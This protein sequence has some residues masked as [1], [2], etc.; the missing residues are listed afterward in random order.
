[1]VQAAT[2]NGSTLATIREFGADATYAYN[3]GKANTSLEYE[4][5][6]SGQFASGTNTVATI[7]VGFNNVAWAGTVPR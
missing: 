6:V 1:M 3:W 5:Y 4:N 7:S 2:T